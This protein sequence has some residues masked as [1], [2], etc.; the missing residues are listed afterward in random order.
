MADGIEEAANSVSNVSLTNPPAGEAPSKNALKKELK[1]KKKEEE[2]RLKEE[3]KKKKVFFFL[4]LPLS[5]L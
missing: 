3:E 5:F 2:N 4:C 1:K